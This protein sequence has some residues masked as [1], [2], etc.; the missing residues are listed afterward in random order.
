MKLGQAINGFL[1]F[2]SSEGLSPRTVKL[3]R[4][5][6]ESWQ[7][8]AGDVE[9]VAIAPLDIIQYL[10]YLRHEYEPRRL[11]GEPGALSSQTLRNIWVALR[12]FWTWADETLEVP[13]PMRRIKAPKASNVETVPLTQAEVKAILSAVQPRR[14][15][16]PRS[17]AR[18]EQQLRDR[19]ILLLLLDTGLRASEL[20]G[21]K[22]GDVELKTGRISVAGKGGKHRYVWAAS[23]TRQALWQYHAERIDGGDPA[24]P[25]FTS[26]VGGRG[27]G[28][29]WLSRRVK[30]LGERAGI[31]GVY[32]H[33]FRH[34]FAVQYLRNGGDVFTL[35]IL[36]GHSSLK[37]VRYYARLADVDTARVHAQA[38]PVDGW[39]K[40]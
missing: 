17:G 32:P 4:Y 14:A 26:T 11:N 13:T 12:S 5:Y 7:A 40:G 23:V 38:S 24:R 25:L 3:Y 19:A 1:L 20:C 31:D 10:E 8:W 35:Q 16:R 22:V 37:M 6:L 21:L 34:T 36:L 39:L 28:R 33:R 18:Y 29:R 9:L 30:Q 2:K 27:I 15:A